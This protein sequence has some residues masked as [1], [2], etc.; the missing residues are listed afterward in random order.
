MPSFRAHS[1][2]FYQAEPSAIVC[3]AHSASAAWLA[4]GRADGVV[5]VWSTRGSPVL[6][7]RLVPGPGVEASVES[8]AW[9][10]ERL[11]SCGL[12]GQLVEY[13][14]DRRVETSRQVNIPLASFPEK[15]VQPRKEY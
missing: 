12:H 10:G 8:L 2:R 13:D 4:A 3:L 9:C 6:E 7:A 14:L 5:E 15:Q 11:F 1:L